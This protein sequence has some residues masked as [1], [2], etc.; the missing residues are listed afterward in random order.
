MK[1]IIDL[2]IPIRTVSES[3][4]REHW[5]E[6]HVRSKLQKKWVWHAFNKDRVDIPLPCIVKLSRHGVRLLDFD[7]MV[8]CF[9]SVRDQVADEIIPGLPPGKADG[10]PRIKW[11]YDQKK[12]KE[13]SIQI[14]IFADVLL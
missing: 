9:K 13:Y 5:R 2:N 14:E 7:N 8:T 12:S 11:E 3:N 6:K 10:D 1:K 4:S